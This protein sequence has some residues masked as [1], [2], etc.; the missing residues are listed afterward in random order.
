[1]PPTDA[2]PG[3]TPRPDPAPDRPAAAPSGIAKVIGIL[4][5]LFHFAESLAQ[6]AHR[7]AAGNTNF[8]RTLAER[9]RTADAALIAARITRALM[10]ITALHDVLCRRAA[11]GRDLRV[12]P[13]RIPTR[14]PRAA[15]PAA[16]PAPRRVRPELLDP[17]YIPT[18]QDIAAEVR[19]RPIGAVLA[20]I[21]RDLGILPGTPSDPVGRD[22]FVA[23]GA[24]GGSF[25]RLFQAAAKAAFSPG[26]WLPTEPV[27]PGA[28]AV[29]CIAAAATGPP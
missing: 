12:V 24:Y 10:R 11:R 19:R 26:V 21:C 15:N 13:A 2:S 7:Q 18:E 16:P 8:A 3:P 28:M 6:A 20:D 4:T 9:F 14:R 27:L 5:M 17:T 23:V 1:M 22:L 25:V 29:P